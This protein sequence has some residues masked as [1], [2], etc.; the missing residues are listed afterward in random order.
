MSFSFWVFLYVYRI[1]AGC[2]T[3][4]GHGR[5]LNCLNAYWHPECFRCHAC[6]LP[7]SDYEVQNDSTIASVAFTPEILVLAF[8][9]LLVVYREDVELICFFL[10][11]LKFSMSGNFPYHKACYKEHYH[12]KCD[13]CNHYVSLS[14]FSDNILPI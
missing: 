10:C 7:I 6:Q 8:I 4:I 5:F 13:V 2:H 1:C 14:Q 12:P 9:L 3:E 11:S